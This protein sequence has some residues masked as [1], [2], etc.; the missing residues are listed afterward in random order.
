MATTKDPSFHRRNR[1][2]R[3]EYLPIVPLKKVFLKFTVEFISRK[4]ISPF[5]L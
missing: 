4:K 3:K 5:S 1:R 2:G